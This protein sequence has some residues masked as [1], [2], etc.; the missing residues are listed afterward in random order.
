M[1][2]NNMFYTD[3]T[4][5]DYRDMDIREIIREH[6]LT[7]GT[8]SRNALKKGQVEPTNKVVRPKDLVPSGLFVYGLKDNATNK[9]AIEYYCERWAHKYQII[10]EHGVISIPADLWEECDKKN[11]EFTNGADRKPRED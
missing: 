3:P 9:R 8:W 7:K 10:D 1:I 5:K 2:K 6:L 4:I 11:K